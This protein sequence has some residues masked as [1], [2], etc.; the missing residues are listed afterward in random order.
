MDAQLLSVL[1]LQVDPATE[2]VDELTLADVV[3]PPGRLSHPIGAD[4]DL[5][6]DLAAAGR[7]HAEIAV[8][9]EGA[10]AGHEGS[11]G[12][13]RVRQLARGIDRGRLSSRLAR[14]V[15]HRSE[16]RRVGKE[17]KCRAKT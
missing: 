8:L 1:E 10:P 14:V 13:R 11:G 15:H 4:R 12:W 7:G 9:E 17:G 16:E 2:H 6:A 3:V 5:C